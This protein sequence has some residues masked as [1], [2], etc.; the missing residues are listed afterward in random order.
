MTP[1]LIAALLAL[2]A[3]GGLAVLF[4]EDRRRFRQAAAGLAALCVLVAGYVLMVNSGIG[5]RG[6]AGSVELKDLDL[7]PVAGSF[8][9]S[10]TIHNL[11]KDLAISGLPLHLLVEDCPAT[12]ACRTVHEAVQNLLA[13]VPPGQ[14]RAFVLVYAASPARIEGTLRWQ[15]THEAPT[16]YSPAER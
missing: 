8:R 10:G 14:S 11:S 9:L 2:L 13:S 4:R 15:V 3:G 1:F 16:V 6:D 12:G 5:H 7:K